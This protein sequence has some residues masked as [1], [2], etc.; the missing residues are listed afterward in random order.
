MN[1]YA[2]HCAGRFTGDYVQADCAS[3]A[4][5]RYQ[6]ENGDAFSDVHAERVH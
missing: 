2:I 4:V 1:L 6:R 5:S 3:E